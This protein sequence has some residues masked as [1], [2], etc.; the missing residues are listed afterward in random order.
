MLHPPLLFPL[1]V[2]RLVVVGFQ[3][4]PRPAAV[5]APSVP[6]RNGG[7][8]LVL[9]LARAA[10]GAAAPRSQRDAEFEPPAAAGGRY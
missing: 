1:F 9:A 3:Y 4:L 8:S 6:E 7:E 5:A 2:Y 10:H